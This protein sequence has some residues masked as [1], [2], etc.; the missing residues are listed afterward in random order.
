MTNLVGIIDYKLCNLDS[1]ARAIEVCGARPVAT[2]RP[3]DLARFDRLVLPGVGS[4]SVA[5]RTLRERRLDE[6]LHDRV[7]GHGVPLLGICLGMQLLAGRGTE[8]GD[9]EGLGLISGTVLRLEPTATE[10]VPHVGW[11]SVEFSGDPPLFR[12][13]ATGT[14]FYFVHSYHV[15]CERA[16]DIIARTSYCGGFAAAVGQG[17]VMGVQFHPEKSRKPGFQLLRNFLAFQR[18]AC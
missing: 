14:D 18:A 2:D 6:G 8:G 3:S 9:H 4:F 13:I 16:S 11:N 1:I 5:M 12:N 15:R 17:P 10:H 7:L